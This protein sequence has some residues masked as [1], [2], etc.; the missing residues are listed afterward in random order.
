MAQGSIDHV[1]AAVGA[2]PFRSSLA[3]VVRN[4]DASASKSFTFDLTT[5]PKPASTVEVY[6]SSAKEALVHL[7]AIAVKDWSFTATM[8]AASVRTFVIPLSP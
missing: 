7:A 2:Q 6:R 3:L 5:L 1:F 8:P 4:G